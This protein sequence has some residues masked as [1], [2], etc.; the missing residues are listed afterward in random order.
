MDPVL[1]GRAVLDQVQPPPAALAVL[2]QLR[3][4]QPDRRHQI[5]ERQLRQHPRIDLIRLA[6]QRRQPLDPL[7][8]GDQH[9]PTVRDQ[10]VVHEP[11]A[12]HRLDHPA[13]RLVVHRDPTGEPVQAV[14]VR[15]RG[16]V[17]D[18]LAVAR[19]QADIDSPA[20]QIQP[21]VQHE[22]LLS[23][24]GTTKRAGF[25]PAHRVP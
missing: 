16:E 18:Q 6:R 7:R 23:R 13:H 20:T 17:I 15:R 1:Q 8:V 3:G 12:V 21:N 19:N 22:L 11:G 5:P 4:R 14:A 2:A 10:L 25:S 9:L 24:Q